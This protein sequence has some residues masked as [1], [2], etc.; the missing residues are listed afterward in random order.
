MGVV[1]FL[2]AHAKII[3]LTPLAVFFVYV[4]CIFIAFG[5]YPELIV[6]VPWEDVEFA[7]IELVGLGLGILVGIEMFFGLVLLLVKMIQMD[8]ETSVIL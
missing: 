1:R 2:F 6:K 4:P 3:L 7:V 8:Y 5:V